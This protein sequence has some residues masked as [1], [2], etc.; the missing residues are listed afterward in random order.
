VPSVMTASRLRSTAAGQQTPA[1]GT[2][3]ARTEH[4]A[5]ARLGRRAVR[6]ADARAANQSAARWAWATLSDRSGGAHYAPCDERRG[7]QGGV[8]LG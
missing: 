5:S 8:G 6:W 4:R 3:P 1:P 7:L 2:P